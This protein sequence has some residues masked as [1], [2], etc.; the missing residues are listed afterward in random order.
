M[1]DS[2]LTVVF[3]GRL[4]N[5]RWDIPG[6]AA[7]PP[8]TAQLA[9][10]IL[11]GPATNDETVWAS[12]PGGWVEIDD[13]DYPP[14]PGLEPGLMSGRLSFRAVRL[15][16]GPGGMPVESTDSISV[17]ANLSLQGG[18]L[19]GP[20]H[21]ARAQAVDDDRGGLLV[22]WDA[23][24]DGVP[25]RG[26]PFDISHKFRLALPAVGAY[27][28]SSLTPPEFADTYRWPPVYSALYYRGRGDLLGLSAGGALTVTRFVPPTSTRFGEIHGTLNTDLPLWT[29]STTA[30]ADT[31]W[32]NASFAVQLWPLAGVLA[33]PPLQR[34]PPFAGW[35]SLQ[36]R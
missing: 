22:W 4:A 8:S 20:S 19:A 3:R 36:Q 35:R 13:A 12:I 15:V 30:P 17:T 23:D 26:L 9:F 29:D 14:A 18:P 7:Q 1:G 11:D 31:V 27:S 21:Y 16:Q 2:S 28:V 32:A 34:T 33:A 6:Y 24:M 25:G 10:M 5:G